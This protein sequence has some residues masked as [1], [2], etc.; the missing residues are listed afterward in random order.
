MS[1]ENFD[2]IAAGMADAIAWANGEEVPGI[3]VHIP[4]EVDV[5]KVR[6]GVGLTQAAFAARFGFSTGSVR[7]WEQHRSEP[8]ASDRVLLRVIERKPEAV[9]EALAEA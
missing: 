2:R 5:R 9:L 7:D 4:D 6:K 8:R 1:K 3:R